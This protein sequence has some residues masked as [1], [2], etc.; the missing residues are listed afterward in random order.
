MSLTET[1][2]VQKDQLYKYFKEDGLVQTVD[3][4]GKEIVVNINE[5]PDELRLKILE[6]EEKAS[7]SIK[8]MMEEG[9]EVK[10][11]LEPWVYSQEEEKHEIVDLSIED[12]EPEKKE[13]PPAKETMPL[14]KYFEDLFDEFSTLN[15]FNMKD[16]IYDKA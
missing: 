8:N 1:E 5:I 3:S 16:V 10:S 9:Q 12:E 6:A 11:N 4:E 13:T 15:E 7:D 14:P 2:N